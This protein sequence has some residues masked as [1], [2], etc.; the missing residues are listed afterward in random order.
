[1]I[2]EAS[3]TEGE[4]DGFLNLAANMMAA[5]MKAD[6]CGVY[7]IDESKKTLTQRAGAGSQAPRQVI[8]SYDYLTED[9][10]A[11]SP[12]RVGLTA[13]IAATGKPFYAPNFTE[14]RKHKHHR[15][16]YDEY[17]FPDSSNTECGAFLGG[18][19]TI[20]G[21][22]IGV[23]KVEN[24]AKKG[25][26]DHRVFTPEAQLRFD[27]LSQDLALAIMRLQ[28]ERLT[29]FNVISKAKETI[30]EILRDAS[31]VP[32]LVNKVVEEIAVLLNARACVLFLKDGN[33]LVQPPWAA[34][35]W[36]NGGPEVRAYRLADP[37]TVKDDPTETE[38]VGLTVWIAVKQV[39]FIAKS[40]LELVRHPHHMGTFDQYNFE[41]GEKCWSFMG[42]PLLA[43]KDLIGVLKVETKRN[44]EGVTYFSEQDELVFDLLASSVAIA[45]ANGKLLEAQSFVE[46]IELQPGRLLVELHTF[47]AKEWRVLETLHK[48]AELLKTKLPD[49]AKI[50]EL[51]A[52]LLQ[53]KAPR[54]DLP[55]A[56][57]ELATTLNPYA[58]F[59]QGSREVSLLMASMARALA[60]KTLGDVANLC[61]DD[62][63]EMEDMLP[64]CALVRNA[65]DIL[66]Q[67][68]DEFRLILHPGEDLLGPRACL[69]AMRILEFV[70]ALAQDKLVTL[71]QVLAISIVDHWREILRAA[72]EGNNGIGP[73]PGP[74]S[75]KWTTLSKEQLARFILALTLAFDHEGLCRMVR[76]GLG[77]N[78]A[79]LIPEHSTLIGEVFHLILWAERTS[80]L[81]ALL[82]AARQ[83]N[84]SNSE[85]Q[86][87]E[88]WLQTTP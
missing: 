35:G 4:L 82:G 18:P 31:D 75:P 88:R 55:T 54:S 73:H 12:K 64:Q 40:N 76:I 34:Y 5:A 38:K 24:T 50:V 22:T 86:A 1:M 29:R 63:D 36:A 69:R 28:E 62:A 11:R 42:V 67:L 79:N 27:I 80:N 32:S 8:R 30:P 44:S 66:H 25:E 41:K 65:V 59:L 68:Y 46:Q 33:R 78:L 16:E 15:G 71:E 60:A 10:V 84:P 47:M 48:A 45:I 6:S 13:Y 70:E 14:L 39:K 49:I 23:V 83:E 21:T 51:Y 19:L 43:G 17:N 87:F 37:S 81:E 74:I 9:E 26:P 77:Q 57:A 53:S 52:C 61:A 85:L 3:A 7:L 20:G 56:V 2:S 72:P 58:D